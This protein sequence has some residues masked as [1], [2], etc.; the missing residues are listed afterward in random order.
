[1][2][3]K[4][5]STEHPPEYD[6]SFTALGC[7]SER[8]Y[9]LYCRNGA[10][11]HTH[12]LRTRSSPWLGYPS[13]S[14]VPQ[15]AS[16]TRSCSASRVWT[17]LTLLHYLQ[18]KP[19]R[20]RSWQPDSLPQSTHLPQPTELPL[21][22]QFTPQW[23]TC[24]K[25]ARPSTTSLAPPPAANGYRAPATD[26]PATTPTRSL[27]LLTGMSPSNGPLLAAINLTSVHWMH[28]Y[29]NDRSCVNSLTH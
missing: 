26:P 15:Q 5:P 18:P 9:H 4:S 25:T 20:M 8:K 22:A 11:T 13:T 21:L 19:F 10:S 14:S 17:L 23:T 6:R 1:M 3:A 16:P 7:R 12:S 2:H 24:S 29:M 28:I 27:T